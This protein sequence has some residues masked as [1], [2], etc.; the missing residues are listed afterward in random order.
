MKSLYSL[1]HRLTSISMGHLRV[2]FASVSKR[3]QVRNLSYVNQF[4][5]QVQC[6][7][8]SFSYEKFCTWTRFE[9][10]AEGNSEMAYSLASLNTLIKEEFI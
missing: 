3:V 9:A 7:S 6:K 5:S 8:N 1:S 4:Y 2:P 10:E